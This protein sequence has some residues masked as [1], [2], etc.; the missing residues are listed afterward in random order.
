MITHREKTVTR[1]RIITYTT[2][3]TVKQ[4]NYTHQ[5]LECIA[6]CQPKLSPENAVTLKLQPRLGGKQPIIKIK[7]EIQTKTISK[8][9][10]YAHVSSSVQVDIV[11]IK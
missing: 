7:L 11:A 3:T 5:K 8:Q 10:Y 4:L 9:I 1:C 6:T 2:L